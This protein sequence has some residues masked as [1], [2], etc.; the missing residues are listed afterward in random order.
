MC[1]NYRQSVLEKNSFINI[2][3]FHCNKSM[4]PIVSFTQKNVTCF[5]FL[6]VNIIENWYFFFLDMF[7][8]FHIH[9][10]KLS[11][12]NL[13]SLFLESRWY[14]DKKCELL[15]SNPMFTIYFLNDS[16]KSVWHGSSSVKWA[17]WYLFTRA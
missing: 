16:G 13:F 11:L 6:W 7:L 14:F 15:R 9:S 10:V 17:S 5:S 1:P 3:Q 8:F 12:S 2:N 4:W